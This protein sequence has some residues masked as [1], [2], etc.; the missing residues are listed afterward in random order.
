MTGDTGVRDESARFW[1][2]GLWIVGLGFICLALLGTVAEVDLHLSGYFYAPEASQRWFLQTAVPWIWL[3]RYGEYPTGLLA[4]GAT[5]VWY[6]SWRHRAWVRYR[7]ACAL[8]VLATV[9]GPGLLVN[10]ILKPLWGR[11]RPHQV[12]FFGGSRSYRPWWQPGNFGGGKSF[13]SGHAA[14]GYVLVVGACL[15]SPRRPSWLRGLALG[16]A[17]AY[18]SLVG[19]AR[20]VHGAHFV[21]DVLWSGGLMCFIVATLHAV[22]PVT[23]LTEV[24][25]CRDLR[26]T[27]GVDTMG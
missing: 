21:S 16:G 7:R 13:S 22:L 24:D 19:L 3:N 6:R 5:I 26:P 2:Y 20:V 14:M 23:P 18:G 11:P 10:G 25:T 15:V 1:G 27:R 12:E 4:I 9:L 17:L 8:L